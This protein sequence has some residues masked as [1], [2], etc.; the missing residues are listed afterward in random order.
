MDVEINGKKLGDAG[1]AIDNQI[2]KIASRSY[3]EW[4]F[5]YHPNSKKLY[6]VDL[7]KRMLDGNTVTDKAELLAEHV[8]DYLMAKGMVACFIQGYTMGQKSKHSIIPNNKLLVK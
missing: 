4:L 3:P 5:E 6:R 1:R 2:L 7:D 8:Q